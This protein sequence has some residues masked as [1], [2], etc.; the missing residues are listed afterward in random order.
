MPLQVLPPPMVIQLLPL[1]AELQLRQT[2]PLADFLLNLRLLPLQPPQRKLLPPLLLAHLP[3]ALA[4][5]PLPPLRLLSLPRHLLPRHPPPSRLLGHPQPSL[6]LL[7][8]PLVRDMGIHG[9]R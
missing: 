2:P 6:H 3:P 5:P 1:Y 9:H 4:V 8:P 7:A